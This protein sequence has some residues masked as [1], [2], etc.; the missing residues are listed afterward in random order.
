MNEFLEEIQKI[1]SWVESCSKRGDL[2]DYNNLMSI[3]VELGNHI[4]KLTLLCSGLLTKDEAESKDFS[5]QLHDAVIAGHMVRIYKLFDQLVYFVSKSKGEISSIFSRLLFES[6]AI[7]K[8]LMLNGKESIDSF[9]KTSFKSTMKNYNYVKEQEKKRELT[10]IEKRMIEKIENRIKLV[11]LSIDN[12][13]NNK[14][15]KIDNR[16]FSDILNFLQINDENG[17]PWELGYSF[18]FGSGSAFVHGTWYDIQVNHLEE[19]GDGFL[20][21]YTYDSVDP[22]YILPASIIP[23]KACK[24]YLVWRNVDPDKFVLNILDKIYDL[25]GF[26]NELDEIRIDKKRGLL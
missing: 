15:W 4:I 23:V 12:L 2:L 26:L 1:N 11:N 18:L 9:I 5:L 20:P 17:F 6:Y 13:L 3:G 25:L 10:N 21:K 22:R 7:M 8:Y 19:I 14:N 24:D 16:S